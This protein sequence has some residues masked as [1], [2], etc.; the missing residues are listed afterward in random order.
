MIQN[1]EAEAARS[2]S[3]AVDEMGEELVEFLQEIVRIPTENP[4]GRHY[5][6]CA[7]AIGR[8]MAEAG[9]DVDYVEV[10]AEFIPKLAPHGEGL[11]RPSVIGRLVG[12]A[13]RPLLHFT[14]HYDVVP[15]G[16]GWERRSL[17]PP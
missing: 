5:P 1:S 6:D 8:K 12:A 17:M 15:A 2:I 7:K 3:A 13:E 4:P 10:P 11:P 9:L 14:G 16:E